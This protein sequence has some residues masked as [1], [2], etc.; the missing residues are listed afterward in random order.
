M[1]QQVKAGSTLNSGPG[2][3]AMGAIINSPG[4]GMMLVFGT[5]A[6]VVRQLLHIFCGRSFCG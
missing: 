6:R 3:Q 5:W 2:R 1:D 4:R